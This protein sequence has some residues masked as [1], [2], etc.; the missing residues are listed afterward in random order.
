[1]AKNLFERSFENFESMI[2]MT[3]DVSSVS[4]ETKNILKAAL[5]M[6]SHM[7]KCQGIEK[8]DD[9]RKL[10]IFLSKDKIISK[11]IQEMPILPNDKILV[12]NS[13][14]QGKAQDNSPSKD[15]LLSEGENPDD[16][17]FFLE[18]KTENIPINS[19]VIIFDIE[20][21]KILGLLRIHL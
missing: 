12:N 11:G 17:L 19:F 10:D 4:S 8:A 21:K 16:I 13:P 14:S 1:M 7:G 5:D 2:M 3:E 9:I 18:E 6:S 20:K 15:K